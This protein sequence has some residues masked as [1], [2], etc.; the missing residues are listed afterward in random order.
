MVGFSQRPSWGK[1]TSPFALLHRISCE[2]GEF[3]G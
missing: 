2:F 3:F 1:Q